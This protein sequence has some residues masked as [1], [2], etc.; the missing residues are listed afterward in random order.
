M[1]DYYALVYRRGCGQLIVDE[2]TVM[3]DADDPD[4]DA[5]LCRRL[6]SS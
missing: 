2:C 1:D 5:E 6:S 4:K 3:R